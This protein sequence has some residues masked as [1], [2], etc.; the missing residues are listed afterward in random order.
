MKDIEKG[1]LG[2]PVLKKVDFSLDRGQV[3]S[4]IGT[5]GAGKSTLS[6]IIAGVYEK[7]GGTVEIDGKRR[8]CGWSGTFQFSCVWSSIS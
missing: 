8:L 3:I 2:V 5:N 4:I 7:D 6:N 1:F